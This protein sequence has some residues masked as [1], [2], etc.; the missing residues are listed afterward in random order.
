LNRMPAVKEE[1]Q[2]P[3]RRKK[4]PT[5][6]EPE[7]EPGALV[8]IGATLGLITRKPTA[9]EK[10]E[11]IAEFCKLSREPEGT[12]RRMLEREDYDLPRA[13]KTWAGMQSAIDLDDY[14]SNSEAGERADSTVEG[15]SKD[16]AHTIY[17][18]HYGRITKVIRRISTLNNVTL[19][20]IV[21]VGSE[22]AGKSSTLERV[23]GFSLFPRDARICTR[24][25]IKL[26]LINAEESDNL[27]TLTFPGRPDIKVSE[28]ETS[29]A[30]GR[31]MSEVVPPGRGVIDEQLTIEVRKPSVPTLDLIDLP[32]IVA[33]SIEGEPAD[34]MARTRA[35]S[36]RYLQDPNTIVVV[37]VPAN[38]T[39][40]RDSQAI[41]LVQ[42]A[43]KEAL[44]LGV[45]AK[46]DLAHD[47]RFRQ[48][49][50]KTPYWELAQRLLGAADDMVSLPN[51]WVAVKNRDTLIEEEEAG[52]LRQSST[53]E[54]SWFECEAHLD[55]EIRDQQCGIDALLRRIDGLFTS[56]I[57]SAWVPQAAAHLEQ[58]SARV[59]DQIDM[60]GR[61]PA[62]L[63]VDE[64]VSEFAASFSS[65]ASG[66]FDTGVFAAAAGVI[67]AARTSLGPDQQFQIGSIPTLQAT[68]SKQALKAAI[69]EALPAML[70]DCSGALHGAVVACFSPGVSLLRLERFEVLRDAIC[71]A[72]SSIL[73]DARDAFVEA[74]SKTIC[75]RFEGQ[76]GCTHLSSADL[77]GSLVPVLAEV[78][79]AELIAPIVTDLQLIVQ[80]LLPAGVEK[81]S[82]GRKRAADADD[83]ADRDAAAASLLV[84]S[85][86]E[87]RGELAQRK[88]DLFIAISEVQKI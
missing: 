34:M 49:K 51:G 75:R 41:Q 1:R 87:K 71:E 48:R 46:A 29:E 43:G 44:T 31:L 58:E 62:S 68:L 47:P 67:E 38:I 19:P 69:I 25:P 17:R 28:S 18:S 11:R 39:R 21:V 5:A 7:V 63:T 85:C 16:V 54:H 27:V 9:A 2:A 20:S 23:A 3:K 14:E 10:A 79:L 59:A 55:Q 61:S 4:T 22:S 56:H 88:H 86:A 66:V 13:M 15:Q 40:V 36:Q 64:L 42:E 26:S 35:I 72:V 76:V 12:A 6:E 52:G 50:Q 70:K 32:G 81:R 60:L 77:A 73:D 65:T 82:Q 74:A 80:K 84:E 53:N 45:L 33:A 8:R 30:V 78:A 57:K 83:T 24:M 37:V